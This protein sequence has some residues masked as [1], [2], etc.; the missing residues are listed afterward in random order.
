MA[1]PEFAHLLADK[2]ARDVGHAWSG[3]V[4][5]VGTRPLEP[6]TVGVPP[7]PGLADRMGRSPVSYASCVTEAARGV[8]P[9][10]ELT[11]QEQEA[12]SMLRGLG[13]ALD[14]DFD[15]IQL[16]R[17]FRQLALVLHP[18]RH[19]RASQ[20]DHRQLSARFAVLCR[21]Y[22]ALSS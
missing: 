11:S 12:L 2:L 18:D 16:K 13:A 7:A 10:R 4:D 19:P 8:G 3:E 15:Q 17:A 6:E 9:T 14:D 21:A 1:A 22:R 5:T 20:H